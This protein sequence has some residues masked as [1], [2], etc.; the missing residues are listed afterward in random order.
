MRPT[1]KIKRKGEAATIV[2]QDN[3][4][5]KRTYV[6]IFSVLPFVLVLGACAVGPDYMKPA[7]AVPARW[8]SNERHQPIGKPNLAHWWTRLNDPVLSALI[9]EAVE[10]NLDVATAKARVREARATYRES[11]GSLYP[12]LGGKSSAARQRTTTGRPASGAENAG[13]QINTQYQ[14]GFDASWEVDLFGKNQRGA[15]A[16]GYGVEAADE[17]LRLALLTLVGDVASNYVT[18]RGFQARIALAQSTANAQRETTELTR[19]RLEVG[20]TSGLDLARA[21]GLTRTTEAA[22]PSLEVSYAEAVHRLSVLTG[23]APGDLTDRMKRRAPIPRPKLPM[24]VGIPA[25]ILLTR[26]DVRQAERLLAQAT[27]RIGRAEASRYPAI[28]LTG[29]IATTG[30]KVGD[31][32][33]DSSIGWSFGPTLNIPLFNGGRLQAAVEIEQAQRDRN[34]IGYRSAVLKALEEVENALIALAQERV[35]YGKLAASVEAYRQA[36]TLSRALYRSGSTDFLSVLDAERSLYTA[37]DALVQSRITLS[38]SFIALNKALGG[39]WDGFV[40]AS[41]PEVVDPYMG[42]RLAAKRR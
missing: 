16:A 34:F 6:G 40:D 35:R 2:L 38:N 31:L 25:D 19:T 4:P 23:R 12:T 15:E 39:G 28:S 5:G 14:A 3:H 21:T 26:P 32:A 17:Q 41:K 8:S 9:E 33:K 42:P 11:V 7:I 36:A 22:I 37:E 27:A 13:P 1:D 10:G 29:N 20:T 18:A 30:L 24:P